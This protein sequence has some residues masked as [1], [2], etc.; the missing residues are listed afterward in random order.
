MS[1]VAGEAV[2]MGKRIVASD[3]PAFEEYFKKSEC[4]FKSGSSEALAEL[5]LRVAKNR[6]KYSSMILDLRKEY[7]WNNIAE[8]TR[9]A[10]Q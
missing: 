7:D 8:T 2:G 5:I 9:Q 3:I 4:L 1:A 6:N 10:Y